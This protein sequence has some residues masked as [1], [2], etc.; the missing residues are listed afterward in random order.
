MAAGPFSTPDIGMAG[1][2]FA[3]TGA[4]EADT[5]K[6]PTTLGLLTNVVT[7]ATKMAVGGYKAYEG[8]QLV[9]QAQGLVQQMKTAF[10]NDAPSQAAIGGLGQLQQAVYQ[11]SADYSYAITQAN[12]LMNQAKGL[13]PAQADELSQVFADA[14]IDPSGRKLSSGPASAQQLQLERTQKDIDQV[15]DWH[16]N[17]E[18]AQYIVYLP[19]QPKTE[20]NIDVKATLN[21]VGEIA[22]AEQAAIQGDPTTALKAS[23]A[24]QSN[25]YNQ[26]TTLQDQMNELNQSGASPEKVAAEQAKVMSQ[27]QYFV[28]NA[29]TRL[30]Q[31]Q[32]AFTPNSPQWKNIQQ[33]ITTVKGQ[34]DTLK[35]ATPQQLIEAKTVADTWNAKY[36]AFNDQYQ[37][38][39]LQ[40]FGVA[41]AMSKAWPS[42]GDPGIQNAMAQQIQNKI[43]TSGVMSLTPQE[44]GIYNM[45]MQSGAMGGVTMLLDN[46]ERPTIQDA[47]P[48]AQGAL[49]SMY[50]QSFDGFR[51]GKLR[52]EQK[53]QA[54]VNAAKLINYAAT[55][56]NIKPTLDNYNGILQNTA[57]PSFVKDVLP[58]LDASQQASAKQGAVTLALNAL[59]GTGQNYGL[60]SLVDGGYKIIVDKRTDTITVQAPS[61]FGSAM[62]NVDATVARLRKDLTA[63]G[64][65]GNA[66]GLNL[67]AGGSLAVELGRQALKLNLVD[68]SQ[69]QSLINNAVGT[70]VN[71]SGGNKSR[72]DAFLD[73]ANSIGID[74]NSF[75]IKS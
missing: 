20:E 26:L 53:P 63:A 73:A 34:L 65:N 25:V 52:D 8:G 19:N 23:T 13:S 49:S 30:S 2:E 31:A 60:R 59:Q 45:N 61:R 51:T 41:N 39:F 7:P 21:H 22:S 37:I 50:K 5:S 67:A 17:P 12:K 54:A 62:K 40:N 15:R 29:V 42:A 27:A 74:P 1:S 4:T 56:N 38:N 55:T 44:M 57:S 9:E 32:L 69:A 68:G 33:A 43:D 70:I 14:G 75:E 16:R 35:S 66:A 46:H 28:S 11:G 10:N 18:M 71:V 64:L 47:S 58:N 36:S 24:I 72:A 6:V 3:Q 48:A